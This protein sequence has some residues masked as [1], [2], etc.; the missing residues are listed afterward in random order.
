M[1][2]G[3]AACLTFAF[4]A[5][6]ALAAT[7]AYPTSAI[8]KLASVQT[9]VGGFQGVLMNYTSSFSSSFEGFV[10][11]DL[12]NGAGETVAW[13]LGSCSFSPGTTNQCFVPVP[14]SV[15]S[16]TYTASVFVVTSTGIP[17]STT[18]SLKV[19]L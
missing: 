6:S 1:A 17:V 14:L 3:L 12:T 15:T 2:L 13:N 19:T 8:T 9:Q 16:G 10:Y 7:A 18:A 11:M 5:P 4:V